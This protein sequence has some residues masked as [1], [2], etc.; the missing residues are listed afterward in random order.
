MAE[1]PFDRMRQAVLD[2]DVDACAALAK[3]SVER[4]DDLLAV[5]ERGFAAGIRE[6]GVLWED[7][8]YFLPELV[9]GAEAIKAAMAIVQPALGRAQGGSA[10]RVR[11]VLGPVQG[12]L[13]DIGKTLVGTLLEANGFEVHDLG[14][15]VS[16][17]RF[18][19]EVRA[20]PARIVGASA[21]LTTTMPAQRRLVEAI[22]AAGL[23]DTVS[24]MVGGAPTTA[25]W[26][27]AI[28]AH[29]ADSA[30]D[31]VAVAGRLAR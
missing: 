17:E 26:A 29:H 6:V 11:V 27:A 16:V 5:V 1:S 8:E 10:Q 24:V 19:G 3:A 31:A 7:G 23:A 2:G 9:Q 4:G 13:H 15:D 25:R 20:R 12:D 30:Q 21:L 18:V 14:C 28:G 22:A